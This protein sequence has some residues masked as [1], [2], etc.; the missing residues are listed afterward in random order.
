MFMKSEYLRV[1]QVLSLAS[2][3]T[4]L[5]VKDSMKNQKQRRRKMRLR[6][7]SLVSEEALRPRTERFAT[8]QK[9]L[10]PPEG[11]HFI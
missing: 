7:S 6:G 11:L 4:K 1:A 2:P 5:R 9:T 10:C 8:L 3:T